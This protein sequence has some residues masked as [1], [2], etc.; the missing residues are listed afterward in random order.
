MKPDISIIIPTFNSGNTLD[1]AINSVI[2][3]SFENW[4]LI[5]VNDGSTDQS[6][7]IC[8]NWTKH[9]RIHFVDQENAGVSAAR[10]FGAK[11]A[12]G[13]WLIFLDADDELTREAL[14]SYWNSI[15][16]YPGQAVLV[17]G[18]SIIKGKLQI[19]RLPHEGV[20]IAKIPGTFCLNKSLFDHL[21]GYDMKLKF[22]E[23]TELFHRIKLAGY[24]EILIAEKM[25][26]YH[27]NLT[28][29]S[30][31]L[32]NII[33]SNLIILEKHRDT[34]PTDTK[35]LYYQVIGVNQLRLRRFH[36]ARKYLWK[37]YSLKPSKISTLG[38]FLISLSPVLA[39]KLYTSGVGIK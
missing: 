14:N 3:Q 35:Q 22:S 12:Q 39:R 9:P 17:G 2:N 13:A 20:Y 21:V 31:N 5:L 16:S 24:K 32:Q 38:R 23:N 7:P 4:E 30:K 1:R 29:G 34:L 25:I 26:L 19:T 33:D 37:A 27:D 36:E 18:F 6:Y 15:L 8:I 11:S 10:N 28:G